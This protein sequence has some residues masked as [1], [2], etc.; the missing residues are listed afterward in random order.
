MTKPDAEP[1]K[2]ISKPCGHCGGQRQVPNPAWLT[3]SRCSKGFTLAQV[4][5]SLNLGYHYLYY[6]ETGRTTCPEWLLEFYDK[7]LG[8]KR[9]LHHA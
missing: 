3:W 7:D 5:M 6:I 4:S 8:G 9:A 2:T 1:A